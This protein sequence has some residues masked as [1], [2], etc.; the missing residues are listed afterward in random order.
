MEKNIDLRGKTFLFSAFIL[1][2]IEAVT[3]IV[4]AVMT[5]NVSAGV[6][7][8]MKAVYEG[9]VSGGEVITADP[10]EYRA[11]LDMAFNSSLD[12]ILT[13]V[14]IASIIGALAALILGV[15]EFIFG[16]TGKISFAQG[17]TYYRRSHINGFIS[18]AVVGFISAVI[19]GV[20]R[21]ASNAE[22]VL[23]CCVFMLIFILA[24]FAHLTLSIFPE[25]LKSPPVSGEERFKMGIIGTGVTLGLIALG[26]AVIFIINVILGSGLSGTYGKY[27]EAENRYG[28]KIE[29]NSDGSCVLEELYGGYV[30]GTYD[31]NDSGNYI[32]RWDSFY[33][34]WIV[35]KNGSELFI[36]GTG[37]GDGSVFEKIG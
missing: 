20:L 14:R 7:D 16:I 35:E 15:I 25:E 22:T 9:L 32:I 5:F 36:T 19:T 21:S 8:A 4:L 26:A 28:W 13:C 6:T 27:Y 2:I 11:S 33:E 30:S 17:G 18:F 24:A 37:L 31:K 12:I 10:E 34:T 23:G 29:F 3:L 1:S